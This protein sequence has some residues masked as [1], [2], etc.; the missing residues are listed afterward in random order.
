MNFTQEQMSEILLGYAN[1]NGN[2]GFNEIMKIALEVLMKSERKIHQLETGDYANGYRFRNIQGF[3]KEIALSVP[4][5]RNGGFYPVLLS[6]LRNED[7]ERQKLIFSLYRKGLTTEQIGSVYDEVYGKFY[8]KSQVSFLMNDSRE[9]IDIW[10]KRRLESHYLVI[11]IDAT[12][13]STRR[14]KCVSKEAY[15]S[16]LGVKEDGTR[17]VLSIVNHP[18]EGAGLWQ[19]EF[20]E[21]KARGVKTIGL[22]VSDGLSSIENAFA[23]VFTGTPHQ[24]CV[25][26][27]KRNVSNLFPYKLRSEVSQELKNVFKIES[28]GDSPIDGFNR[29]QS[30][31]SKWESKYPAL[32]SYKNERNIYYF[33]YT[34]FP[35]SIQRM[36]YS[37]NWIERLNRDYKRT[38]KMRGSMPSPESVLFLMGS[39]GMEKTYSSYS[40]P[41]SAFKNVE[42][43]K[44]KEHSKFAKRE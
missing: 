44:S 19:L 42:E 38:L 14:D 25:V 32:K 2:D 9:E 12:F 27:F 10:L 1:S 8:S 21:L 13:V 15:Y 5:T 7:A 23:K 6:V 3:G 18:T 33:T 16:V 35:T 4:R 28:D 29:L 30:F 22:V 40:Y 11:Y 43:L 36:I 31:I 41:V 17:E 24:L 37:T 39:V 34:I 26:H 20:E